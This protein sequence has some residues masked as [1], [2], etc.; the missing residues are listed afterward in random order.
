MKQDERDLPLSVV[1]LVFGA[2]SVPLAFARHLVSLAVV[3]G[4]LAIAFG[5]WGRWMRSR[6]VSCYTRASI[7]RGQWGSRLG[8]LGTAAALVMWVL[9][10]TNVL[11]R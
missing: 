10:A 7:R 3:L 4:L 2:L 11:L 5:A 6:Q 9:W 8:L 1:T